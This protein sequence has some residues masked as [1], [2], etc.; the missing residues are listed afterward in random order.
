MSNFY[1]FDVYYFVI[2]F[3]ITNNLMPLNSINDKD[4]KVVTS[5]LNDYWLTQSVQRLLV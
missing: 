4:L 3:P 2:P 5:I 1:A